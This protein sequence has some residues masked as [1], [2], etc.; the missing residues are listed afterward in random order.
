MN[1]CNHTS[2]QID[3]FKME[4][5]HNKFMMGVFSF[6]LTM[7]ADCTDWHDG[8]RA[9]KAPSP[10]KK[11]KS[12]L[13]RKLAVPQT[14]IPWFL[15]DQTVCFFFSLPQWLK[16]FVSMVR[17]SSSHFLIIR[18]RKIHS[19]GAL[20]APET[21]INIGGRGSLLCLPFA[22]GPITTTWVQEVL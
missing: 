7:K 2:R 3:L 9:N 13:T 20:Q 11:Q 16:E 15:S 10:P 22:L 19:I 17:I 1:S 21:T 8:R 18:Y 12:T 4:L 14:G 6:F 5:E